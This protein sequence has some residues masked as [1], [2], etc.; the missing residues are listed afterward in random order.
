MLKVENLNV[1]YGRIHALKNVSI[2]VPKGQIVTVV[3]AN[4]AG[5]STLMWTLA[6]VLKAKSGTITYNGKSLPASAHDVAAAGVILVPERRRLYANLTVRENIIMGAFLRKDPEG[7]KKDLEFIYSLFPILKERSNQYAGTLSGGEQQMA[8]IARG[9]MS[10]PKILLLDEPSLG[11]SPLYTSEVFKTIL[12]IKAQGATIFLAE[13]N[14][15]K[16]LEIADRAYVLETGRVVLS[17]SGKELLA[18]PKVQEAYLG[19]RHK[20]I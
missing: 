17:G 18:N 11:L 13:Q 2:E 9:L 6:G 14:A 1:Y 19:V 7:I 8:A 3:G 10:R 5:K 15:H 4:G 20:A 16:A 12:Q